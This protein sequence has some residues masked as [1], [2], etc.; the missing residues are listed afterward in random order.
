MADDFP[1]ISDPFSNPYPEEP[2]EKEFP[3]PVPPPLPPEVGSGG[4]GDSDYLVNSDPNFEK[5]GSSAETNLGDAG[6]ILQDFENADEL[7]GWRKIF[8]I[9]GG[10]VVVFVIMIV[11]VGY[12]FAKDAPAAEGCDNMLSAECNKNLVSAKDGGRVISEFDMEVI[13]PPGALE[14]DTEIKIEKTASGEVTDQFR[15]LPEGLRF[16]KP[17]TLAIPYKESGLKGQSPD[18]IMLNY[19]SDPTIQN[20]FATSLLFVVDKENKKLITE[21]GQL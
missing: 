6:T 17:V 4:T 7:A 19:W 9:V 5:S 11:G 8:G 21:I 10:L 16:L 15:L 13:V 2:K 1:F 3:K 20:G 14:K 12:Y 18:K